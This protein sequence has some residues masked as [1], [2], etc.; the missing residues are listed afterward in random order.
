MP[1]ISGGH[2]PERLESRIMSTQSRRHVTLPV[3]QI[4]NRTERSIKIEPVTKEG[5]S[6]RTLRKL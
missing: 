5:A 3:L 2:G 1:T 4:R 6:R